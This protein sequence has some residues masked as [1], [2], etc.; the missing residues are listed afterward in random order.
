VRDEDGEFNI[1]FSTQHGQ[2]KSVPEYYCFSTGRHAGSFF[3]KIGAALFCFGHL[4]HMGLNIAKH[5]Y[6][7]MDSDEDI[8]EHCG[9]KEGL[10]YHIIYPIFALLQLFFLFKYG[11]VIVNKNKWLA[12]FTF[13]HCMSCSLS[14]WVKTLIN[15]TLDALVKKYFFHTTSDCEDDHHTAFDAFGSESISSYGNYELPE[16]D[17]N[18][19]G[20]INNVI[21]V[22]ETL[23]QCNEEEN[24]HDIFSIA[25]WLYPFSVE[26]NILIVAIWYVLWSGIGNIGKHNKDDVD[27]LMSDTPDGS[28]E[29]IQRTE[30]HKQNMILFA[31]CTHSNLGLF[32]GVVLMVFVIVMALII[33][34]NESHCDPSY[35]VTLGHALRITVMTIIIFVSLLAYFIIST[36][37]VNPHPISFLDDMLLFMCL[38]FFFLYFFVCL[39]PSLYADFDPVFFTVNVLT[40]LQVLIQTPMIVDGLRRCTNSVEKQLR[41]KGRNVITFLLI[42]NLAVYIMETLMIKSYDYQTT[43]LEFYG[44]SIWTVL[45]H[46]TLPICIFYRFHSAV[47]LA[48]IWKSAYMA[49]EEG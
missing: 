12:R 39:G 37:D 46:A 22:I 30:G 20:F 10:A 13:M 31:D 35:S 44:P 15:E 2:K 45:S 33:I 49:S 28:D 6:A 9:Q 34:V 8:S 40:L 38:P 29:N 43:K 42:A 19:T 1:M 17:K 47:A 11:N 4:I 23:A 3:L 24:S 41:F 48:D 16:C 26:F 14:F 21:C 18:N 25:P 27:L 36:L 32:F 7:M 5:I